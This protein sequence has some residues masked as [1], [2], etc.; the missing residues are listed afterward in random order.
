MN[1]SNS[2]SNSNSN[3][4]RPSRHEANAR[5]SWQGA[6]KAVHP[7]VST[8]ARSL[9]SRL[10]GPLWDSRLSKTAFLDV[11]SEAHDAQC[12]TMS[13]LTAHAVLFV[14]VSREAP[15]GTPCH[16][17]P[18]QGVARQLIQPPLRRPI[19]IATINFTTINNSN[20]S[21]IIII[22]DYSYHHYYCYYC[23][24]YDDRGGHV[25]LLRVPARRLR[26]EQP[27][28]LT[29]LQVRIHQ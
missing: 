25:Q 23:S 5:A 10:A 13:H 26:S 18:P 4:S 21:C 14:Q 6:S 15:D 8:G 27:R 22:S 17:S 19:N 29:C 1:T 28:T 12:N 11:S 3:S 24:R 20:T 2:N 16:T 7:I 9:L